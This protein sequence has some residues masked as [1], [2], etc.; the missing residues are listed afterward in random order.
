[1]SLEWKMTEDLG[2]IFLMLFGMKE[3][4]EGKYNY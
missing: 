2:D 3:K 4:R 1:M